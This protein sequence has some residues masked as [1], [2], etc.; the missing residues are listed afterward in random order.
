[1]ADRKYAEK[2]WVEFEDIKALQRPN[3]TFIQGSISNVNCMDRT[4]TILERDT[5]K[6][7][8][9]SYDYF[10]TAT[11]LRRP[12]PVVPQA[13]TRKEYLEQT[14]KHIDTV[15]SNAAPVLVV[16]GGE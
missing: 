2:A 8:T 3:V 9:E 7:R 1:M 15:G 11:G 16:G 5:K 12:W 14:N 10:I 6:P 4:A 13:L